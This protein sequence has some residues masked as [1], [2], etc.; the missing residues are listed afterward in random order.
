[1]MWQNCF[2]T[3][4]WRRALLW[5]VRHLGC[6]RTSEPSQLLQKGF[7]HLTFTPTPPP[8]FSCL[9]MHRSWA[10][11]CWSGE[12][13]SHTHT[14]VPL[15]YSYYLYINCI[16]SCAG[17]RWLIERRVAGTKQVSTVGHLPPDPPPLSYLDSSS[18]LSPW[19]SYQYRLV[20][21]NQ[22]GNTTGQ[23]TFMILNEIK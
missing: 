18:A 6:L 2:P 23:I 13:W 15:W 11:D 9:G 12:I 5:V 8:L 10:M 16:V 1:M 7:R 17:Q 22:A 14:S 20:L 19:T 4:S 21:Y 3:S